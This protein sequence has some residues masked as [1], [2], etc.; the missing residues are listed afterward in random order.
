MSYNIIKV[1]LLS[2]LLLLATGSSAQ[3]KH[4]DLLQ[5]KYGEDEIRKV[6]SGREPWKPFP[7]TVAEWKEKLPDSVVTR[8]IKNGEGALKENFQNIPATVALEYVRTGNRVNYEGLSFVKRNQL[9]DLVLAESV[10]GKGR[11]TDQIVNGI[12]SICEESFWGIMAHV[13]MQK[14]GSGLPDVSDPVVDLFAAETAA[15]LALAD[16]FVG[17]QLD[18]V[19]KLIRPR[20]QEEVNRRIFVPME[21]AKYGWMGMGNP[22]AKLNNWAPWIM[23][24]YLVATLL[25]QKDEAKKLQ[26][27]NMAVKITD[28]YINGL[29]DDGACEEGP[30]YWSAAGGAVFDVLNVLHDASNGSIDIYHEPI[31]QNMGAYIYKT[32][33][34]GKY[35]VN[36]SDA[37]PLVNPDGVMIFRFGKAN[38]DKQMASFGS[39]AYHQYGNDMGSGKE[40]F[41]NTRA[42]YNLFALNEVAKYSPAY[43]DIKNAWFPDVEMMIT[44]LPGGLFLSAH[45]GHNGESHNHNDVGD[46]T[47]YADG[48]P[49]I[50]DIGSGTYT[51]KTFSNQRYSIWYNNSAYHN[52]PTINGIQQKD[53]TE[54]TASAVQYQAGKTP[55][56]SMNIEK[57]YPATSGLK[58]WKREIRTTRQGQIEIKDSYAATTTVKSLTQSF[59]TVCLAD[60][61]Q[62]GKI[63]FTTA[64]GKRVLL[65]YDSKLWEVKKEKIA[66]TQP[67]DELL[68]HSWEQ[69]DIYRIMFTAKDAPETLPLHYLISK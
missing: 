45:G 41:R 32:H 18:K 6:F 4:R 68:K 46:F 13:G 5:N 54:F 56:L 55:A 26:S 69:K 42:L 65:S 14:A 1:T 48:D 36:V 52:L 50:I 30:G 31:I 20:I 49:V 47:V 38:G 34:A 8:L 15:D 7:Q 44:R 29:G 51:S 37:H 2:G 17:P 53:G 67:E 23:S 57:A 12:W 24:N 33:I 62:P 59:M 25:L 9:Y 60:L 43:T 19:S 66:L 63:I 39:W 21:T 35:F 28:Q 64:H 27:I 11:F 10:E 58:N 3:V 16:Y 22:E 40:R 61:T